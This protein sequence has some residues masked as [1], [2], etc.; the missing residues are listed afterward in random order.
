MFAQ[1]VFS[2]LSVKERAILLVLLFMFFASLSWV[3]GRVYLKKTVAGP[4]P[5]G[6]YVEGIV[7]KPE[8]I[9]PILVGSNEADAD[10]ANLVYS[11]LMKYN[12]KQELVNDIVSNWS[13]NEDKTEYTMELREDAMF[14]DGT[15]LTADDVLFTI[16]LIQNPRYRSP[17]MPNWVNVEARANGKNQVIFSLKKPFVPFLHNLTFGIL[18]KHIWENVNPEEFSLSEFNKKPVGSGPYSFVR[19]EKDKDGAIT[20]IVLKSNKKH[21]GQKPYIETLL[22]KFYANEQA[23][24]E[25][26][27]GREI[28][29]VNNISHQNWDKIDQ[30]AVTFNEVFQ[31]R[32][33]A[34][35]FNINQSKALA[36]DSA[37]E[38]L[39]WATCR[40]EIIDE[41]L[42]GKGAEIDHPVLNVPM[43]G[44]EGF[45]ERGCSVEKGKEILEKAGWKLKEYKEEKS[46]NDQE[47]DGDKDENAEEKEKPQVYTSSAKEPLVFTLSTPDYPELVKTAEVLKRQWESLGAV[48]KVEILSI[49]DL[50]NTRIEP[51]AYDA[52]L[53]GEILGADPDPRPYWHSSERKSPGQNLANYNNAEADELLDRAR[54]EINEDVRSEMYRKFQLLINRDVPAVFLYS[55]YYLYPVD[56]KVMG[57]NLEAINTPSERL[58]EIHDWYLTQRWVKK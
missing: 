48:V 6:T 24:I 7:G 10:L 4:A 56:K 43:K 2:L 16:N 14:H 31:S 9:N 39:A 46:N 38:A 22:F 55:P 36:E 35:F 52:L 58:S 27:N 11:G 21:Y 30:S 18:P 40:K 47:G 26:L 23:A 25:A 3:L 19:L 8:Y 42:R 57:I 44:A 1:K 50:N 28:M 33:F 32:Y 15:P 49:G 5:G 37:R 12:E 17:L 29:G 54:E 53:F 51:R 34:V 13:I 45:E 41:V 20:Q